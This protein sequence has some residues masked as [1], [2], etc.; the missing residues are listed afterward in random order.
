MNSEFHKRIN[1]KDSILQMEHP[2]E[3]P[4]IKWLFAVLILLVCA[5]LYFVSVSVLNVIARKE[6]LREMSD[7][8]SSIATMEQR[9]FHISQD[10][11]QDTANNLGLKPV[12]TTAYVYRPGNVG[13]VYTA[14]DIAGLEI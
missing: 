6:A 8:T 7:I 3:R 11:T 14:D 12:K 5:Y 10:M 13:V 9:Y 2:I 1:R 4:A